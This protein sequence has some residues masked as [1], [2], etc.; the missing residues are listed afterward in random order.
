M[1]NPDIP[2]PGHLN[3]FDHIDWTQALAPTIPQ[4][5]PHTWATAE[6]NQ[7]QHA[8]NLTQRDPGP[9]PF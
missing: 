5:P 1:I 9:P 4:R 6:A 3:I 7:K 8:A 2:L